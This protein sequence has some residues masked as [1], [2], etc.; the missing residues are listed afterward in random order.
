MLQNMGEIAFNLS[1]CLELLGA[2][3]LLWLAS[4]SAFMSELPLKEDPG[5]MLEAPD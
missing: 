3:A 2:S 4:I 5:A 1:V